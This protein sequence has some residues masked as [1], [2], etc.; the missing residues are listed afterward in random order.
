V[1]QEGRF[2]QQFQERG[3]GMFSLSVEVEDLDA[4]VSYLRSRGA[5]TSDPEPGIWPGSRVA[6]VKKEHTHGVSLQLIERR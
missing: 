4:A 2:Y 6:R 5:A 1:A 3:E